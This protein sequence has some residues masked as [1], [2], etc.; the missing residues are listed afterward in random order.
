MNMALTWT[1]G[2]KVRPYRIIKNS[3][4]QHYKRIT[5]S[6]IPNDYNKEKAFPILETAIC[7]GSMKRLF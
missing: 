1:S 4:I 5:T 7:R 2:K 6:K 3:D